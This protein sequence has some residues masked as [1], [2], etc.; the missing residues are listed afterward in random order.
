MSNQQLLE[1]KSSSNNKTKS[2]DNRFENRGFAVQKKS[3]TQ[4]LDLKTQLKQAK[5]F[6]HNISQMKADQS[7]QTGKQNQQN[8]NQNNQNSSSTSSNSISAPIRSKME[9]SFG[10]SFADVKIHTNSPQAESMGALAF[11]QGSNVHFA[12]GQYNPE[13]SSGQALLGH[14]LTHVVQQRAGRVSVPQQSKG[15][16]V[17]ADPSLETEAD[18]LGAKA[19]KGEQVNVP[20]TTTNNFKTIPPIQNSTEPVQCFLPLLGAGL[21][22]LGNMMGGSQEEEQGGGGLANLGGAV[23]GMFGPLGEMAGG[24][25]GGVADGML[26]GGPGGS[27]QPG[28]AK[29]RR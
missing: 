13:N 28:G 18:Q 25:I 16:K 17:N 22:L 3:D 21:G 19:A 26:G 4:Q 10:T 23:G 27:P 14:E 1:K 5:Q 7:T 6:G 29:R 8:Q 12:S 11:T 9:N 2:L 24:L 20:G 15:T